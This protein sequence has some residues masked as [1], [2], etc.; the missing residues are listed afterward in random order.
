[1]RRDIIFGTVRITMNGERP[2]VVTKTPTKRRFKREEV[3]GRHSLVGYQKRL[4]DA[5]DGK[6]IGDSTEDFWDSD[7]TNDFADL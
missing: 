4:E 2:G 5:R 7:E 3:K 1:V 6:Y